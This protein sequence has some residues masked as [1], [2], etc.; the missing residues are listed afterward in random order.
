[1]AVTFGAPNFES[2]LKAHYSSSAVKA[3]NAVAHGAVGI[4]VVDDPMLEQI[5]EEIIKTNIDN[6][7]P[8]E[9]L[10]KLNEIKKIIGR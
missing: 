4:I 7:T 8:L 3:K 6:L 5:R 1:M 9:A 2:S 10:N